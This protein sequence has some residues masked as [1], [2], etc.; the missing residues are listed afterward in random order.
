[1][2]REEG[3]IQSYEDSLCTKRSRLKLPEIVTQTELLAVTGGRLNTNVSEFQIEN[4]I[5]IHNY[6]INVILCSYVVL[7]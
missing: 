5:N 4:I 7:V 1:M 3:S 2:H 6:K